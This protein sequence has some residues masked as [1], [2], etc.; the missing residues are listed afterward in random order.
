MSK[1]KEHKKFEFGNKVSIIRT[2]SGV[3]IGGLSF[4]NEYDGHTIDKSLEQVDRL[5]GKRPKVLAGARGCRGQ[6]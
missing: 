2:A 5:I 4:R 6:R 3:I 1:W